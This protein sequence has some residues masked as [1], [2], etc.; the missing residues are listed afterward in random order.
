MIL[1]MNNMREKIVIIGNGCA[2]LSAAEAIREKN[3]QAEI[4]MIGAEKEHTYYRPLLSEYISEE[5]LPKRFFLHNEKWYIENDIQLV[6]GERATSIN[7]E[8]KKIELSNTDMINYDKLIIATGSYN[9]IPP[10]KGAQLKNVISLRSLEDANNIKRLITSN[11]KVVI[12]GGGLLGLELGWQLLKLGGDITIVE[13][14]DRL[15]PRQL[16]AE[17]S[18]IFCEKVENTGMRVLKGVKTKELQGDERVTGVVLEDNSVIEC[19]LC[20]FSIGIRADIELAQKAGIITERA[21]KT[22][23]FMRTNISDVF[24]A[25][26]CVEVEGINYGIWPEASEQ[27]RIAGLSAIGETEQYENIIPFNIYSGMNLRLF[28]IGDVGT[29]ENIEYIVKGN[30]DNGNYEKEF[31]I[32]DVFVGGILIGDIKKSVKYKNAIRNKLKIDEV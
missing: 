18:Q 28:S 5:E 9:F 23:S 21:I 32:E 2:G 11:K 17:A 26:D 27:G 3:N 6:L 10:I 8:S 12:I 15:L 24:A 22:D 31:Y 1:A 16:D 29:K 7:T 25:G 4:I 19:D 20:I 13:M 30:K 14:M